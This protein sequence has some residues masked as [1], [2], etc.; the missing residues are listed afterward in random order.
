MPQ[1]IVLSPMVPASSEATA[2]AA[3]ASSDRAGYAAAAM[4]EVTA[5]VEREV[6]APVAVA[7]HADGGFRC[8]C[9]RLL[10]CPRVT[11]VATRPVVLA[12]ATASGGSVTMLL[13]VSGLP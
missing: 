5:P 10:Q 8:S 1:H 7:L 6:A 12:S 9:M 3:P 13:A 2:T 4:A 11:L